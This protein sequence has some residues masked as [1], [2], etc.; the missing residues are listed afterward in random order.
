METIKRGGEITES[1]VGNVTTVHKNKVI[2]LQLVC[3]EHSV[4]NESPNHRFV[5]LVENVM[6]CWVLIPCDDVL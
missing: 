2:T 6:S 4:G 5:S 3:C 1:N